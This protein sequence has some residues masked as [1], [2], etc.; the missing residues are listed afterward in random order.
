MKVYSHLG[1]H[2]KC[3]GTV[4][5]ILLTLLREMVSQPSGTSVKNFDLSH[6]LQ[7]SEKLSQVGT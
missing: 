4:T 5:F 3:A 1:T 2:L 7:K 6:S